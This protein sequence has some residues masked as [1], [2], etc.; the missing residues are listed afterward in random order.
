LNEHTNNQTL[1]RRY[2]LGVLSDDEVVRLEESYF[3]D[4]KLFE[5]IEIAEDELVDAYVRG[6]LSGEDRKRFEKGLATSERLSE[7]VRFGRLLRARASARPAPVSSSQSHV[8]WWNAFFTTLL[9]GGPALKAGVVT[10]ALIVV[11][12][13]S[14]L[15]VEWV[16]V[17]S[18]S[19]H[20]AAERLKLEQRQKDLEQQIADLK[21]NTNQLSA[22][23]QQETAANE[24]LKQELQNVKEQLAQRTQPGLPQIVS[25]VLL[26]G[27]SRSQAEDT[28]LVV[29]PQHALI[30]L[31]LVLDLDEYSTYGVSIQSADDRELVSRKGL[32]ARGPASQ[33]TISV[34]FPSRILR[35]GTY[36]VK[37]TGRTSSGTYEPVSGYRFRL[38]KR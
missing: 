37:V 1:A 25:A 31:D 18:E 11:L 15:M 3:A 38:S 28:E 21:S 34:E 19:Q 27:L 30:K 23:V 16:R 29:Q 5:E 4:D 13:G 26:S 6:Q 36:V 22:T 20:I 33:R 17:R 35:E 14:A 8:S 7:R 9:N 10:G 24:K 2:L 32:R 12:G